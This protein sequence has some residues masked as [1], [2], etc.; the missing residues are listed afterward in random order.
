MIA[1]NTLT[2]ASEPTDHVAE[3]RGSSRTT[4]AV[5]TRHAAV[6]ATVSGLSSV[7]SC[8]L[9]NR[10]TN[11]ATKIDATVTGIVKARDRNDATAA[12]HGGTLSSHTRAS[13]LVGPDMKTSS[14]SISSTSPAAIGS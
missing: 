13:E 10:T 7:G 9:N 2:A 14:A 5:S 1:A 8:T 4:T 12:M 6:S 3:R 11:D